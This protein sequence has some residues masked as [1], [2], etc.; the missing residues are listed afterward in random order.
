MT[1]SGRVLMLLLATLPF[2]GLSAAEP[3]TKI[4]R[5]EAEWKKILTPEQYRVMR[6]K[7]TEIA[8]SGAYWQ[9]KADGVYVCAACALPIFDSKDKFE[10]R[11]GWPSFTR[12][13]APGHIIE[14][15][16]RSFGMVRT[17]VVCARCDSHFGHVFD[18]GPRPTGLRYC[19]NSVAMKFV[20]RSEF[21]EEAS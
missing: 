13:Y 18:D 11:T 4:Q 9:N 10:S 21:K 1:A 19:I 5:S 20:P 6:T 7:G 14:H 2:G 8:C 15:E 12:P 3:V 17:E 16:D